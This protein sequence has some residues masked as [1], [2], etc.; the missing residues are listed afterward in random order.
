[1]KLIKVLLVATCLSPLATNATTIK[2]HK[3]MTGPYATPQEVTRDCIRCH[4]DEARDLSH[5]RHWNWEGP[6][7]E[8]GDKTVSLGKRNLLNNYCVAVSSNEP[9]CT[10]CHIGF[11]WKD[12][13]F[14][15][16]IMENMD[17]LVCHDQTGTYK[18]FPTAAGYPVFKEESKV[19]PG[20]KKTYPRVDLLKVA[21]SVA[22]PRNENCGACHFYGGGGHN[23]KHGDLTKALVD[24][25]PD[26]DAHM[27]N[28]DPEKR[29]TCISCHAAENKHDVRGAL[30]GSMAAGTNHFGCVACHEGEVHKKRMRNTLNMH[31]LTVACE[32]CHIPVVAKKYP[33][34]TWWD[35][36]S[37]GDKKR[38]GEKDENGMPLYDWK[39]GDFKWV[40]GLKPEYYWYNGRTDYQLLGEKIRLDDDGVMEF[41]PL[42]G[43]HG[44]AKAK[45]SPF[46]VMRGK[47]FKD[48]N[49]DLL[50]VPHLFGKGGYWK[51]LDWNKAFDD[52]MKSVGLIY[53]GEYDTVETR[54][55]WPLFHEVSAARDALKCADCHPKK[56][57]ETGLLD[58]QRLGYP[59]DPVKTGN[60]RVNSDIVDW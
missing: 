59:G 43:D 50:L 39:K 44:D 58:W 21:L 49:S 8:L 11:G 30:H 42:M 10:S 53:S 55:Y 34:K 17:C 16:S 29:Q 13:N 36:T 52:G 38:K 14:D 37:A 25:T 60:S 15:L 26:I 32:T 7:F 20:N 28:A 23:V 45:I 1:M 57:G 4:E 19:F 3:E 27:G 24:P 40:K 31:S 51:T 18:K 46:K 47:Q 22:K 35:W 54:M 2:E 9:R 5:S 41:N 56:E 6:A 48:K 33:T 12:D